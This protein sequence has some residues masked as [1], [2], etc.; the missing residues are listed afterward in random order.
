MVE[1][2]TRQFIIESGLVPN[3]PG[4]FHR[5]SLS[6]NAETSKTGTDKPTDRQNLRTLCHLVNT[7]CQKKIDID[8]T[9][10][11]DET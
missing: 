4:R 5:P 11:T 6:R 7:K 1:S 8:R 9:R 3:T 2:G 10:F